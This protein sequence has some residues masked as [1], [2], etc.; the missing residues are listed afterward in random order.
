MNAIG[1]CEIYKYFKV[2]DIEM[3]KVVYRYAC[4][5]PDGKYNIHQDTQALF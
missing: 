2:V 3:F 1:D 5:A 4:S